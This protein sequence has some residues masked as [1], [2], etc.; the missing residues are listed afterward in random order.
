[1]TVPRVLCAAVSVALLS[2]LLAS[3]TFAA[4][5]V[6]D[7]VPRNADRVTFRVPISAHFAEQVELDSD[8]DGVFTRVDSA[9][10]EGASSD[11]AVFVNDAGA[12]NRVTLERD[13]DGDPGTPGGAPVLATASW[14]LRDYP[15]MLSVTP[16][17]PLDRDALY[18][19]IVFDGATPANPAARRVSDEASADPFEITFRTLPLGTS[20]TVQ[21]ET[22]VPPSL[23][24][25]EV[26]NIYLPAGYGQSPT[27]QYPAIYL[28]HGGFGNEDTWRAAAESAI[29]RLVDQGDIEP[30]VAVMPDGNSGFCFLTII[31]QHRLWSNTWDGQ[32]L[33]GDYTTYDLPADVESRFAVEPS[34]QRRAVAGM[35]MG[36]FGAASVGLGHTSEFSL[37]APLAGWQHS[38]RMVN[39]PGF[40][41]CLSTHWD[42]IPDFGD[43]CPGGSALQDALGP[44]GSTDLTHMKTVNGRD[45][46]LTMTD[47][48]F[49]GNIFISHGDVDTTATVEWSDDISC[50]LE[51]VGTAHCYKRP[52]GV[53]H[54]GDLW[55]VA[56]EEDV[57]PRF[58]AI[59]YWGDLPTDINDHCV[60]TTIDTAQD[61]DWDTVG[62]DGDK[63]GV[64]GDAPCV[65]VPGGC[66]DNCRDTPNLAQLDFDTD[67]QG[68]AC[69]LDDDGDGVPDNLDCDPLNASGGTPTPAGPLTLSGKA[70]TTIDW[71]DLPTADVYDLARGLVSQLSS[72][73]G[74]CLAEDLPGSSYDDSDTPPLGDAFFYLVRGEDTGCGGNGTWGEA[75]DGSPRQP[76]GCAP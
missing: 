20:G 30:V 35:S 48:V 55:D 6:D 14:D 64:I 73:A 22:F 59:A 52:V 72:G 54:T 61:V 41:S 67:G 50:A 32:F 31:A 27:Q 15:P 5:L 66:D 12:P 26:Y 51:D 2:V 18:R 8:G 9:S 71:P 63:S 38:V 57:L 4:Q 56:L 39:P 75:S 29:N 60:N 11:I 1:M 43:G 65:G 3:P 7:T 53:G 46:A 19:L 16:D 40:P 70:V 10:I 45:L 37:V 47:D 13:N 42:T 69:D 21:K 33:Y 28:L 62:D 76:T 36:G 25:Q 17:A 44:V 58:N 34:R 23:G 49:R 74:S 68:D 24:Y